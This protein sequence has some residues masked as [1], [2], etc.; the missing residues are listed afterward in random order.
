MR[1]L[2]APMTSHIIALPVLGNR[3]KYS[4]GLSDIRELRAVHVL[5]RVCKAA[6]R[7]STCV[8]LAAAGA[9]ASSVA[10]AEKSG[11]KS[12]KALDGD[13]DGDGGKTSSGL[14][15]LQQCLSG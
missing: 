12:E 7:S 6:V 9:A 2:Q 15:Q 1:A 14:L 8:A 3:T 4:R 10:E 13:G 11:V 5:K